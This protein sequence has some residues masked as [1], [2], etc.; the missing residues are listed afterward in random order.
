MATTSRF[1]SSA[2][3][4]AAVLSLAACA[5]GGSLADLEDTDST[6]KPFSSARATLVVLDLDGE[7]VAPWQSNTSK[8]IKDQLFYMV[9]QLNAH[10]SVARLDKVKLSKIVRTQLPDGWMKVTYR[11]EIPVGWGA[12]DGIPSSFDVTLPKKIGPQSLTKFTTTYSGTCSEGGDHDVSSSNYWYHFRPAADGCVMNDADV[13]RRTAKV[14]IDASNTEGKY[15]EYDQVW[16][17]GAL[18]VVAVFGKYAD[19]ATSSDDAGIQAYDNFVAAMERDFGAET[20]T[21]PATIGVRPGVGAPDITWT[22][23]IDAGQLSVTALLIDSPKV[24]GATFDAR[25]K[26]LTE[27][28]DIITYNGHAGLGANV[29]ALAKKGN[30]LGGQYTMFFMNGCDTFAYLDD[31]LWKRFANMNPGDPEGTKHLD[32]LTN[33]MPA[34]F[35]SMPTASMALVSAM[36]QPEDPRTFDQIFTGIDAQ[37]VVAVMGEEDNVFDPTP[38]AFEGLYRTGTVSRG[39]SFAIATPLLPAG[40]YTVSLEGLGGAGEDADLYVAKG[41][42]PTTELFDVRPYL[43]G[44]DE[45]VTVELKSPT[46]LYVMVRGYEDAEAEVSH[47]AL[48]ID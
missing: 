1:R 14:R 19:G 18:R 2:L 34:Y 38:E 9:G 6:E 32:V 11:A 16:S 5:P 40:K 26:K 48:T 35:S 21:T 31:T 47:F 15:P 22:G 24:A 28:A 39:E 41:Y 42:A 29:R 7:L 37:Q 4:A 30:F 43:T 45:E 3:L 46:K 36:S 13:V 12:T 8:L 10:D 25:Y 23:K 27:T 17:D 20:T 33:L 44:S